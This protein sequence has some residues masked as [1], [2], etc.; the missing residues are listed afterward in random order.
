MSRGQSNND[1]I[2]NRQTQF[3]SSRTKPKKVQSSDVVK[4]AVTS[5][6]AQNQSLIQ[7]VDV[8][9]ARLENF[10]AQVFQCE[11]EKKDLAFDL[12]NADQM[13]DEIREKANREAF[14]QVRL[15]NKKCQ[16]LAGDVSEWRIHSE[17]LQ[18]ER[19][20]TSEA[21][22]QTH[23]ILGIIKKER[24]VL[25]IRLT[26]LE[27]ILQKKDVNMMT[28]M[29]DQN[30]SRE[31]I[32]KRKEQELIYMQLLHQRALE[33]E[34]LNF[35][36]RMKKMRLRHE[37]ILEKQQQSWSQSLLFNIMSPLTEIWQ[38]QELQESSH[39]DNENIRMERKEQLE[40]FGMESLTS[41]IINSSP[42]EAKPPQQLFGIELP[43]NLMNPLSLFQSDEEGN[44]ESFMSRLSTAYEVVPNLGS[45]V[46]KSPS[47]STEGA[48]SNS[49]DGRNSAS[50]TANLSQ[51]TDF[52]RTL[53][54][55]IFPNWHLGHVDASTTSSKCIAEE[56]YERTNNPTDVKFPSLTS[57]QQV[58]SEI[59]YNLTAQSQR[60]QLPANSIDKGTADDKASSSNESSASNNE[61]SGKDRHGI[62][63]GA[64]KD[65]LIDK[66]ETYGDKRNVNNFNELVTASDYDIEAGLEPSM[67]NVEP[68]LENNY[69]VEAG[70]EID[71]C[72]VE[73]VNKATKDHK[74]ALHKEATSADVKQ[75]LAQA[76]SVEP[77]VPKNES[78]QRSKVV[79]TETKAKV[80]VG[81]GAI[82]PNS[83]GWFRDLIDHNRRTAPTAFQYQLILLWQATRC[84][85]K[86]EQ[87]GE[88]PGIS[89]KEHNHHD[90]FPRLQCTVGIQSQ[91]F[92]PFMSCLKVQKLCKHIASCRNGENC[93]VPHCVTSRYIL[94]HHRHC[95]DK[96]CAVC[97]PV[98]KAQKEIKRRERD[99]KETRKKKSQN[100]DTLASK[101]E[102]EIK[103]ISTKER[104]DESC[105]FIGDG[106]DANERSNE[107]TLHKKIK[108]KVPSKNEIDD[109]SI[110]FIG[111]GTDTNKISN[112]STIV[113]EI[114]K[115]TLNESEINDESDFFNSDGKD[116]KKTLCPKD[117]I[118]G[119]NTPNAG[120]LNGV[121]GNKEDNLGL[122]LPA[123][124]KSDV[125]TIENDD[126]TKGMYDAES[127]KIL[128]DDTQVRTSAELKKTD[129]SNKTSFGSSSNT[130]ITYDYYDDRYGE[131][132]VDTSRGVSSEVIFTQNDSNN[133]GDHPHNS[134]NDTIQKDNTVTVLRNPSS[135]LK[136]E[137]NLSIFRERFHASQRMLHAQSYQLPDAS[138]LSTKHDELSTVK[139]SKDKYNSFSND[140]N[141]GKEIKPSF[142]AHTHVSTSNGQ[143]QW[144]VEQQVHY[145]NDEENEVS[146]GDHEDDGDAGFEDAIPYVFE[147]NDRAMTVEQDDDE[148]TM[149]SVTSQFQSS[150]KSRST[151]TS[152]SNQESSNSH[153]T[154]DD[155]LVTSGGNIQLAQVHSKYDAKEANTTSIHSPSGVVGLLNEMLREHENVK[156]TNDNYCQEQQ[157]ELG[158]NASMKFKIG[159]EMPS[160][161]LDKSIPT[162]QH[163]Q[164]FNTLQKAEFGEKRNNPFVDDHHSNLV[165][166]SQCDIESSQKHTSILPFVLNNDLLGEE[167]PMAQNLVKRHSSFDSVDAIEVEEYSLTRKMSLN[168]ASPY[169]PNTNHQNVTSS[170]RPTQAATIIPKKNPFE[171]ANDKILS[172]TDNMFDFDTND[173][174]NRE[175]YGILNEEKKTKTLTD[176]VY[177]SSGLNKIKN[178]LGELPTENY[179]DKNDSSS[180]CRTATELSSS[181]NVFKLPFDYISSTHGSKGWVPA[182]KDNDDATTSTTTTVSTMPSAAVHGANTARVNVNASITPF[183]VLETK[184]NS[185]LSGFEQQEKYKIKDDAEHSEGFPQDNF[186][187]PFSPVQSRSDNV[188]VESKPVMQETSN[189]SLS[190]SSWLFPPYGNLSRVP[191]QSSDVGT[192]LSD[193][194]NS[195]HSLRRVKSSDSFR[196]LMK[197]MEMIDSFDSDAHVL[198]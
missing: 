147:E 52:L 37:D 119:N 100:Y 79:E 13:M 128:E 60:W 77:N 58:E 83:D 182:R 64:K 40:V 165:R 74:K 198:L 108:S 12:V 178:R 118:G 46:P 6:A 174:Y 63:G 104:D 120:V 43:S 172:S 70:L 4:G 71:V 88:P 5:L 81:K 126:R 167:R 96:E 25:H 59:N 163:F 54:S 49:Q 183:G 38:Q 55:N 106:K 44:K 93:E 166:N 85:R 48:K 132:Q 19:D 142:D 80:I 39:G 146:Y 187:L 150:S 97:I 158:S 18:A 50:V 45:V 117:V 122:E 127:Y 197:G 125:S 76:V 65:A 28:Q 17:K 121:K 186:P 113:G 115:K 67:L 154:K 194:S 145:W 136:D 89:C 27:S 177:A 157:K 41:R 170:D 2:D 175:T 35:E 57:K 155:Q 133:P 34:R 51:Q 62:S 72:E 23:V 21:L 29:N 131:N 161:G 15:L 31:L 141:D 26:E 143:D 114:K 69:R 195:T 3:N 189:P 162:K 1:N 180:N 101:V 173:P 102:Q 151:A 53:S 184:S 68:L 30:Y 190:S 134:M 10:Q 181:S 16:N 139:A 103:E 84:A 73:L 185:M 91:C 179:S 129:L 160:D 86:A 138:S 105:F 111:D 193:A 22:E 164:A 140:N 107:N 36:S 9:S 130:R 191:T 90:D 148:E 95:V 188:D 24:D 196:P 156:K 153:I 168:E 7:Q 176:S 192:F 137:D 99:Q 33:S 66:D 32:V 116:V 75:S 110:F 124:V 135:N 123:I 98:K 47:T 14:E 20:D 152:E 109:E 92:P 8:M 171:D 42:E 78:A 169:M 56:E 94:S 87:S 149:Y 11:S 61:E 82:K 144:A 159:C 112:H